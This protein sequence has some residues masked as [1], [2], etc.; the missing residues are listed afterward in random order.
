MQAR[1]TCVHHKSSASWKDAQR[2]S[3]LLAERKRDKKLVEEHFEALPSDE[4]GGEEDDSDAAG[5]SEVEDADSEAEEKQR[6]STSGRSRQPDPGAAA[7]K[8]PGRGRATPALG[9]SCRGEALQKN[10]AT[11]FAGNGKGPRMLA[12]KSD[13]AAR[14][15][16]DKQSLSVLHGLPL[17]DR[18]ER[19]VVNFGRE[20]FRS[21][22]AGGVCMLPVLG[23]EDLVC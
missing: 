12:A 9:C 23:A 20:G 5:S 1:P 16:Q 10:Y 4:E 3:F 2:L 15:F 22:F 21:A 11:R 6:P 17:A 13:A 19:A 18:A 14:A 7:Q 8:Q